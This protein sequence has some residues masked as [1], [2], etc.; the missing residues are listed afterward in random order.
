MPHVDGWLIG[1]T[2][3]R[4]ELEDA[5]AS[6]QHGRGGVAIVSGVAG[7]GKTSLL[8]DVMA[9]ASEQGVRVL[10][11]R[12]GLDPGTPALW[13]WRSIVQQG[14]RFGLDP[15]SLDA[16][17]GPPPQ[18]RFLSLVSATRDFIR[19]AKQEPLLV[20]LD[21]LQWADEPSLRLLDHIAREARGSHLLVVGGTRDASKIAGAVSAGDIRWIPLSGWEVASVARFLRET[22]GPSDPSWPVYLHH[23]TGGN[24]LFTRE[25]I[26]EARRGWSFKDPPPPE[27]TMPENEFLVPPASWVR[28][29]R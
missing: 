3:E 12:C 14:R 10:R 20:L 9:A 28:S 15:R 8:T 19:A 11:G 25:V 21:D 26:R 6:A 24:P 29:S 4:G 5:L 23:L 7:I 17:D 22:V 27:V 2:V 13:P 16:V 18:A 1:R